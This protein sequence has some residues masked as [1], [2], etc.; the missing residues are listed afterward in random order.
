MA[1]ALAGVSVN[2]GARSA[3]D[4]GE[5]AVRRTSLPSRSDSEVDD[6]RARDD[7]S[8]C[9]I[10]DRYLSDGYH[11]EHIDSEFQETFHD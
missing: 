6:R 10:S 8:I 3:G 4:G 9:L 7:G 11:H 5:V 1:A 2:R